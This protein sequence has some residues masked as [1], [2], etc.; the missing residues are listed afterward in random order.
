VTFQVPYLYQK[1]LGHLFQRNRNIYKTN[2]RRKIVLEKVHN[3]SY[4]E[5]VVSTNI[6]N[7]PTMSDVILVRVSIFFF[8]EFHRVVPNEIR[9]QIDHIRS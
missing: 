4:K 5:T 2:P 7:R 8:V 1:R 6:C 3:N 9:P